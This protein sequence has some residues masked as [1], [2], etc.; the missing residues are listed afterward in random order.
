MSGVDAQPGLVVHSTVEQL[1]GA[2]EVARDRI[3]LAYATLESAKEVFEASYMTN[4]GALGERFRLEASRYRRDEIDTDPAHALLCLRRSAW[5]VIVERLELRRVMSIVAWDKL[6]KQI[7]SGGVDDVPEVSLETVRGFVRQSA[8]D[9]PSY[10]SES[11]REVHDWLRPR[12][13]S[14]E[15]YRTNKRFEIGPKVVLEHAVELGWSGNYRLHLGFGYGASESQ[16]MIA[17]ENVFHALDGRGQRAESH[18]SELEQAICAC[19][20][21]KGVGETELFSFRC[22]RNGNLHLAFKRLDLLK[23]LNE[24]AG[25]QNFRSSESTGSG[26][27]VI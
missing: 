24:I 20:I 7:N 26:L 27:A 4:Q 25:G 8:R 10:L 6:Q 1:V 11:V 12:G 2:Y 5:R 3:V 19:P 18:K 22:Y 23:R 21:G 15:R 17:L 9:L 16:R 14:V 13:H